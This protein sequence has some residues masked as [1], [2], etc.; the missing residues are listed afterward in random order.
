MLVNTTFRVVK[1]KD[2][3]FSMVNNEIFTWVDNIIQKTK[4]FFSTPQVRRQ[5]LL[6]STSKW[7]EG[8]RDY[9]M[10]NPLP[11]VIGAVA[12]ISISS[13]LLNVNGHYKVRTNLNWR[14]RTLPQLI[15]TI[16]GL[17]T[18][19]GLYEDPLNCSDLLNTLW[20]SVKK[21]R[22]KRILFGIDQLI[23]PTVL[24]KLEE[25]LGRF[26]KEP[27]MITDSQD[28]NFQFFQQIRI[29][30]DPETNE[31]DQI[32]IGGFSN[33]GSLNTYGPNELNYFPSEVET[34][35]TP[36]MVLISLHAL[37]ED[38][39]KRIVTYMGRGAIP[40]YEEQVMLRSRPEITMK[41]IQKIDSDYQNP[42]S[43]FYFIGKEIDVILE[44]Y[45]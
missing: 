7:F 41:N 1:A 30:L 26:G 9:I 5:G 11:Y 44:R 22:Y 19:S 23:R 24:C 18:I 17:I 34:F 35:L 25:I 45:S 33:Q 12:T 29:I 21:Y 6:F 36:E 16:Y 32:V 28:K 2:M 27:L 14:N 4:D 10:Q 43:P 31:L 8:K 38:V 13:L 20:D 39:I 40:R 37:P 15:E 3:G 42:H